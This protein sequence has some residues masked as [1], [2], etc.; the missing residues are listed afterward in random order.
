MSGMRYITVPKAEKVVNQQINRVTGES[1]I[2][3]EKE[4]SYFDLL[5]EFVWHRSEWRKDEVH[6]N[7]FNRVVAA[8]DE[9]KEKK[10]PVIAIS[11][12]DYA[13]FSPMATLQGV[14]IAGGPNIRALN[15]LT[16]CVT[17]A[18]STKPESMATWEKENGVSAS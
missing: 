16:Q 14:Q 5:E 7:A 4:Y 18:S 2:E 11:E 10:I 9:A 17:F 13:I 15:R 1:K 3:G 12:G 6:A 8:H